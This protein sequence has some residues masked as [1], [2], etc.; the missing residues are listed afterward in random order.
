MTVGHPVALSEHLSSAEC[1]ALGTLHCEALPSSIPAILGVDYAARFY[2]AMAASATEHVITAKDQS[3][4][5]IGAGVATT[6]PA[7]MGRR[8]LR[9]TLPSFGLSVMRTLTFGPQSK[10]SALFD[11]LVSPPALPAGRAVNLIYLFVGNG[12]LGQ[13]IGQ[14][15][16]DELDRF[17][18]QSGYSALHVLTEDRADNLALGFYDHLGFGRRQSVSHGGHEFVIFERATTTQHTEP[19]TSSETGR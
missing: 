7:D 16:I 8:M 9:A 17:A 4:I 6:Q 2:R 19:A 11:A 1:E 13:G 3:G 12:H 10:R 5:P 15:I 18:V 14:A